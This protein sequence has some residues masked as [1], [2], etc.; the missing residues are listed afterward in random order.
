MD[1]ISS[2]GSLRMDR[3]KRWFVDFKKFKT[4][5]KAEYQPLFLKYYGTENTKPRSHQF[6]AR[7]QAEANRH[8]EM[9]RLGYEVITKSLKY[10][11][12]SD[13]KFTTKGDMDVEITMDIMDGPAFFKNRCAYLNIWG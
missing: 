1:L 9:A 4:Y 13:G 6:R 2:G 10:I 8:I 5:L 7:A 3:G 11:R 12:R